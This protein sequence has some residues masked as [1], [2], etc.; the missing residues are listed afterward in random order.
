M[1]S[2]P[3]APKQ[4]VGALLSVVSKKDPILE[5]QGIRKVRMQPDLPSQWV[6]EAAACL[7]VETADQHCDSEA[8]VIVEGRDRRHTADLSQYEW[9]EGELLDP[10]SGEMGVSP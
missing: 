6:D 1:G 5:P 9:N 7:C 8:I 3:S 4:L 10:L 2:R